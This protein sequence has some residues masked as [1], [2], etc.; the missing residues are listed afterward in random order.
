LEAETY[1][2]VKRDQRLLERS[3]NSIFNS[4]PAVSKFSASFGAK[5]RM[6]LLAFLALC[7]HA[8]VLSD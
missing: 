3:I 4:L 7:G 8:T 6:H 1:K 5:V 2:E